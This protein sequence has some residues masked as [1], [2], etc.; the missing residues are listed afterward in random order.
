MVEGGGDVVVVVVVVGKGGDDVVF[1]EGWYD[2]EGGLVD[3]VV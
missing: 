1:V 2:G 3:G